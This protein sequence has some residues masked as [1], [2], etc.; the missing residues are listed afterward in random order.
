[1]FS[2]YLLPLSIEVLHC[3][4]ILFYLHIDCIGEIHMPATPLAWHSGAKATHLFHTIRPLQGHTLYLG[5]ICH[6]R[7]TNER[8]AHEGCNTAYFKRQ[9][10]LNTSLPLA[11][12]ESCPLIFLSHSLPL[13]L[14][15]VSGFL[16]Y[17]FALT[18]GPVFLM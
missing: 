7:F 6:I 18:K 15:F 5:S 16:K 1:M 2:I 17:T 13:R 14:R 10:D 8:C 4:V 12:G 3:K 11:A 9:A